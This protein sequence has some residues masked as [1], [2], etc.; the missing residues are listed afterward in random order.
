MNTLQNLPIGDSGDSSFESIR[1]GNCL[2]VDKTRH[3]FQMATQGKYY[4][5][6]R[7]RRFGKSLTIST[8]RCLFQGRRDLFEGLWVAENANWEWQVHPVILLDFNDI[9]H[10][11]L[12]NLHI[13]LEK[14]PKRTAQGYGLNIDAPLIQDLFKDLILALHRKTAMPVV[15]LI[16]EYDKPLIDQLGKGPFE[17]DIAKANR[18]ALKHF[19]GVIKDGDVADVLRFVLI[20]GVSK[21]SRVSIFSELNNLDDVT[22]NRRYAE[23]PG[24]TQHELETSF[25]DHLACFSRETGQSVQETLDSFRAYYNGYRFSEKDVRVYNPFSILKALNEQALKNYWF[26]TGTPTMP[27]NL[28]KEQNFSVAKIENLMLDEQIFSVYDIKR[29]QPEAL[30][31][32]TGYITIREV[33]ENELYTFRYPNREVKN[34]FLTFLLLDHLPGDGS[35]RSLFR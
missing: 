1:Q 30:L 4:F 23:M 5:L 28:L 15:I 33:L 9:S 20:T 31:F 13:S 26:E 27:V 11:T 32:Q 35:E 22:M 10:D 2:Y 12:E 17:M 18:D 21:F 34:A 6:S 25:A 24:Y 8:F 29:L 7:P 3:F 19:L 14:S 16:D